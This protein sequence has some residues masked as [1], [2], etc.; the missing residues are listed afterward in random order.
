MAVL[1]D[2]HERYSIRCMTHRSLPWERE[3]ER[4]R[5]DPSYRGRSHRFIGQSIEK[6]EEKKQGEN[7]RE[8]WNRSPRG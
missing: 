3:R 4:E 6:R 5:N 8:R 2:K 1:S 7:A